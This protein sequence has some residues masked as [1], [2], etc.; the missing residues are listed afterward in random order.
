MCTHTQLIY[1]S[2]NNFGGVEY[3]LDD[4]NAETVDCIGEVVSDSGDC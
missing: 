4:S 2:F 3:Y 1:S